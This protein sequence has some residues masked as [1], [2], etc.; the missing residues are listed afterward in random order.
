MTAGE[1]GN[2]IIRRT[3]D[4]TKATKEDYCTTAP[5]EYLYS[6][7]QDRFIHDVKRD[8]MSDAAKLLGIRNFKKRYENYVNDIRCME[9]KPVGAVTDFQDQPLELYTGRWQATEGGVYCEGEYQTLV[10]CSH[11]IMPVERL[12]NV[13]TG[14]EK[15]RIAFRA[16]RRWRDYMADKSMLASTNSIIGLSD[17]GVSVTSETAKN[18]VKYFQE[19][20]HINYDRIPERYSV[21]RL[22]WI[23]EHGFSPYVDGLVFDG[24]MNFRNIFKSVRPKGS[25]AEWMQ[26]ASEMRCKDVVCRIVLAASLASAL[27]KPCETVSFFVHLWTGQAATGK[28]VVAMF[29]SSVWGNPEIGEYT[30]TFHATAV[31][32]E[33][34]AEFFNSLPIVMDELQLAKDSF[35]KSRFNPYMLAQGSGKGRGRKTGG[36]EKTPT[37]KLCIITTGETPLTNIDDGAGAYARILDIELDRKIISA[38]DGNRIVR[39]INRNYGHIGKE[40]VK[41]IEKMDPDELQHKYQDNV[42]KLMKNDDI[43]D[44]Q[45]MAAAMLLLADDIATEYIFQDDNGLT[46]QELRPYLLTR[47][48]TSVEDRGYDYICEWVAANDNKMRATD[49]GEQYGFVKNNYAYI[50]SSKL[51]AILAQS[52]FNSRAVISGMRKKN[53]ILTT[54]ERNVVRSDVRQT[55]GGSRVRCIAIKLDQDDQELPLDV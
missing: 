19:I 52:G 22:G 54:Q 15:M 32:M 46:M 16:G 23:P 4:I 1:D 50:I 9:A 6:L 34:V 10:A 55:I 14:M 30:Q 45:A 21:G 5:Y 24:D 25:R 28:T 8:E 48:E 31:A 43:Q 20:E 42:I 40:F 37:W 47:Q 38:E 49:Y 44:K 35:G 29:A 2:Q 26:L 53:Q 41:I 11:P 7:R 3:F 39:T 27:V 18:L 36:V 12:V 51:N 33:R 13:D 17:Y